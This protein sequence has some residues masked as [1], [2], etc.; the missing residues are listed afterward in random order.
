[1]KTADRVESWQVLSPVRGQAHGVV[2][3][4]RLIQRQF[5]KRTRELANSRYR[6]TPKPVGTEEILYGDKV[7]STQ[8]KRKKYVWP[9]EGALE[10]VANGEIGVVVGQF[11]GP[12]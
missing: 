3:L 11:K 2:D 4:N 8:N 9:K 10:Y 7:I 5:R 12:K 1:G 6:R